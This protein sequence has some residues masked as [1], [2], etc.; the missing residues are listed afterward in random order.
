MTEDVTIASLATNSGSRTLKE[1]ART[2]GKV[3]ASMASML[4]VLRVGC[5]DVAVLEPS[6]M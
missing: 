5:Y 4:I 3:E 6:L 2:I 1:S